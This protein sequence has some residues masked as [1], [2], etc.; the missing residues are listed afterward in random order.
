MTMTED[1]W[2]DRR[3]TLWMQAESS[4]PEVAISARFA[5]RPIKPRPAAT[6]AQE[7]DRLE[8]IVAAHERG[9]RISRVTS[10]PR[11]L[12]AV[13]SELARWKERCAAAVAKQEAQL[14][15]A[16]RR[17]AAARTLNGGTDGDEGQT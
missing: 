5:L 3:E 11:W 16:R 14:A 8:A 10:S 15:A 9:L 12:A 7:I 1:A 4:N 17:L 6:L 13:P 2:K